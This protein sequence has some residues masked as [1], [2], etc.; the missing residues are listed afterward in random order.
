MNT[1][2]LVRGLPGSGKSS[3]ARRL[4]SRRSLAADDYF[5]DNGV[6]HFDPSRL[7][8]A[9]ADCQARCVQALSQGD[10]AV[11][12]T[13]SCRWELQPY[14]VMAELAG[15]RIIVI[16]LFDGGCTDSELEARNEHGVPLEGIARMRAR[17]EHDWERATR[18]PLGRGK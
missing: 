13:F 12:N 2:F 18:A 15:A 3:L 10:V 1:L 11:A 9:H 17:W 16:D 6:Y 4:V 5:M 8:E 14:L 7:A